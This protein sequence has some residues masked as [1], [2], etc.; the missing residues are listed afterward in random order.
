MQCQFIGKASADTGL[1]VD[2]IRFYEKVG[3]IEHPARTKG[4]F[5]TFGVEDIHELRVIRRLID[6]GFSLSEMKQVLWLQH[7][8][9]NME[10]C[11]AVRDLLLEKLAKV[12]GKIRILRLLEQEL[13]RTR[14]R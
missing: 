4:K 14:G 9:R 13:R 5:R 6:L 2:T 10:A 8:N 7:R 12:R 3:L 1:G 11:T